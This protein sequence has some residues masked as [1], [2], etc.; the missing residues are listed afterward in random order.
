MS[1]PDARTVNIKA[2]IERAQHDPAAYVERQATEIVLFAMG[3][4]PGYESR[5]FLKGGIL[6]AMVYESPRGTGDVDFTT[7]LTATPDF[8]DK[9]RKELDQALLRA[10]AQRGYPDL[11]LRVQTIKERPR[12][13]ASAGVSYPSLEMTIAYARRGTKNADRLA[14]GQAVHVVEIEISFNEPVH[15][16]QIIQL[17]EKAHKFR[18][19]A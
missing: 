3:S 14:R 2:W 10:A 19:T 4:I 18:P 15:A 11:L 1:E 13:F 5:F 12:P 8:A 9:L 7:D 16:I 6:M 17:D